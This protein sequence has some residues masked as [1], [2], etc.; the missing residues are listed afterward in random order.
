MFV[1][2]ATSNTP[3]K[4]TVKELTD[5]SGIL[6]H[7]CSPLH[8]HNTTHRTYIKSGRRQRRSLRHAANWR[9]SLAGGE[10]HRNMHGHTAPGIGHTDITGQGGGDKALNNFENGFDI[11]VNTSIVGYL[12]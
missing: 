4:A 9:Y 12:T 3:P 6:G 8:L 1:V 11:R 5:N 7:R 2:P 10:N